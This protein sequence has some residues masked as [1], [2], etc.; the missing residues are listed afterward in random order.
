[1]DHGVENQPATAAL[2]IAR[3]TFR[4]S[5]RYSRHAGKVVFG[6][7]RAKSRRR[8]AIAASFA[9]CLV[10]E[11]LPR[12]R[13]TRCRAAKPRKD[14]IPRCNQYVALP[15]DKSKVKPVVKLHASET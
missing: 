10:Q 5:R 15:P 6:L 3:A 4:Q 12:T 11:L 14:K 9:G 2:L 1:M 7:G 13:M 8:P